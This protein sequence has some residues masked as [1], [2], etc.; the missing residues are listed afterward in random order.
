MFNHRGKE[1]ADLIK[2]VTAG[3]KQ[4]FGTENDLFLFTGSGTGA[5]EA[6]IVNTLSPGDKVLAVTIGVFGD[7]FA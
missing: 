4:L 1:F 7:R 6:A 5:L 3:L 2:R